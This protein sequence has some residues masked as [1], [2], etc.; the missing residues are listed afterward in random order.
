MAT[1]DWWPAAEAGAELIS[2]LQVRL[3]VP[4]S[5]D[6][7]SAEHVGLALCLARDP[8]IDTSKGFW[9]KHIKSRGST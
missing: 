2:E 8:A 6:V 4:R 7:P 1:A 5:T 3:K 9:P